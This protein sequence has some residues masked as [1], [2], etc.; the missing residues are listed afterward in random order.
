MPVYVV[1]N[2]DWVINFWIIFFH[3]L[4]E[5]FKVCWICSKDLVAKITIWWSDDDIMYLFSV[6]IILNGRL[7][8]QASCLGDLTTQVPVI[9]VGFPAKVTLRWSSD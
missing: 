1:V 3:I 2:V 4:P 6:W 8:C 5:R 9:L 7:E